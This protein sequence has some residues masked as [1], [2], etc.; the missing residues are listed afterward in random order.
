MKIEGIRTFNSSSLYVRSILFLNVFLLI[1]AMVQGA[2]KVDSG[3]F[4]AIEARSI[5]PAAMSGRV[6]A[7]DAVNSDPRIIYV[8]AAS[9]GVWKSINGGD[10]FKPVFDKYSQSI[11]AVA[12]DQSRPETVWVGTGESDTRNSVSVGTGIYKTTDGGENWQLTGLEKSERIARIMIHPKNSDTVYV[13]VPGNLWNSSEDRGLY[14]TM[15][16]GK[17]WQKILYIN[18]DTGCSD[19][20]MD[21]QNPEIVYAA[22]WQF[23]RKPYFF[24]SGGPG[25]GI[26]KSVDGGK[27]WT[28]IRKGLPEGDLG[29]IAIAVAPSKTNFLYAT[30]EAKKT[31]LYRSEDSGANWVRVS[32]DINVQVRPF[33]F[34][35]VY[36]DPKDH[37]RVYKP[38]FNLTMSADGGETFTVFGRSTHSD[39]HAL[40]INPISPTNLILGTDGGIYVSSDRGYNWQF[41]RS[42][43]L[44]QFYHVNF[45]MNTPYNVYGGLQD[46]GSWMGPSQSVSGIQNK[47]WRNVGFGD[48]FHVWADPLD[49]NVVYSEFQGGKILRFDLTS[50]DLKEISPYAKEGQPDLRFNWNTPIEISEKNPKTIYVGAQRV[51]RSMDK[52]ESWEAISPDLTTNDKEKQRQ[53]ESGGITIDNSTAENH[54]TI[55]TISAS[56]VDEKLIW[57]GT[58]DGNL[59][60]T[61]D[62]GKTWSNLTS[63]ITGLPPNTWVSTVEASRHSPAVAYATFD[64]HRTGDMKT[65][66]YQTTDYGQTWKSLATDTLKGYAHVVR[67]DIVNPNLLFVG[68]EFG[69]F[70][71]ID[72]GQ[73][74]AQFTGGFPSVSVNDLAIHPREHDLIIGTHGRGVYIVDDITPIR[75]INDQMLESKLVFLNTRPAEIRFPRFSQEFT[76]D[77]EYVGDNTPEAAWIT[78]YLKDRH[79]MGD[80]KIEVYDSEGKLISTIPAGKRKGINRVPWY[81]RLKPP[82]VAPSPQLGY[83]PMVGPTV[84]EGTYKVKVLKGNETFDS[85]IQLKADPTVPYSAEDRKIQFETSMKLYEMQERLAFLAD[86]I[87]SVRDQAKDR[88]G[89]LQKGDSL[90]KN[91][92]NFANR[93]DALHKSIVAT[94]EGYL[95]GEEQLREKVVELY[96]FVS[97]H[98]GRPTQSQLGKLAVLNSQLDQANAKYEAIVNKELPQ[99]NSGLTAKKLEQINLITKEEWDKKQ[100]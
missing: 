9:G 25:S 7:I 89:K 10:T 80:M 17:T 75:Q 5:G 14:K 96:L 83:G 74:W 71:T 27:T 42:L 8:G 29:R 78:Y 87:V 98:A 24:T 72:G 36:V 4:G 48:G 73:Q 22:T 95:T 55:F 19:V 47:D 41:V 51:F 97:L 3:I 52:G 2:V 28:Q 88:A 37:K 39:H 56:P 45:D 54:C 44:S 59:Q 30:V 20:V 85:Q 49:K 53:A 15:D 6:A 26:H 64:G 13:A 50:G 12:I 94:K 84:P 16:G 67:E 66:V 68:T 90:A 70:L 35:H 82:K 91:L 23:R 58:D 100:L 11:G 32:T 79:M 93:L 57:A 18:M 86:Q 61:K 31:A 63:R 1:T 60:L 76:G 69:L 99:L 21:P 92:T 34:S 77:D 65:Y 43:P 33:Y 62:G 38:G 46:N 81:M 40:Y